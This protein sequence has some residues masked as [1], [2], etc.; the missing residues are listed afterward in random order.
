M[1]KNKKKLVIVLIVLAFIAVGFG[2]HQRIP[3]HNV[4]VRVGDMNIPRSGHKAVLLHDGRVL[5]WG[6]AVGNGNAEIYNPKTRKFS[7]IGKP[8]NASGDF[9]M[10]L[11]NNGEVLIIGY[12]KKADLFDPKT[13]RFRPSGDLNYPRIN[14]TS[15]LL[16]D[17]RVLIA[18]GQLIDPSK[19]LNDQKFQY[20]E[21]SEIYNPKTERFEI[22]PKMLYPRNEHYSIL[23]NNGNVLI[24]GGSS[25]NDS[26]L[27]VS[28]LYIVKKNKFI[29]LK[30]TSFAI[31]TFGNPLPIIL[32]N[33]NILLTYCTKFH[34]RID[35][36][37]FNSDSLT[38]KDTRISLNSNFIGNKS[39]FLNDGNVLFFG[40]SKEKP[41]YYSGVK[42]SFIYNPHLN[43]LIN[44][45]DLKFARSSSSATLLND[46]SVLITGG[47]GETADNILKS[48]ELYIP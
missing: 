16:E 41:W 46:G 18:G 1:K 24:L 10:T 4:F 42:N 9:T 11:L 3:K 40:G 35:L 20:A 29:K 28:E 43:K 5:I 33:G 25:G 34:K 47:K 36:Q 23:L 22:G 19:G 15:T 7:L 30:E 32:N 31:I 8:A 26:A 21:Y 6:G 37:I 27:Y 44:G 38:F 45:P 12:N 48:A 13:D 39:I 14:H 17:G 2:I